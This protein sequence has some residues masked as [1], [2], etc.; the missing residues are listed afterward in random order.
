[1]MALP[2][3]TAS[4]PSVLFRGTLKVGHGSWNTKL[5]P[6]SK[7]DN[8]LPFLA[9][10][11]SQSEALFY[12]LWQS[13]W[14]VPLPTHNVLLEQLTISMVSSRMPPSLVFSLPLQTS[15]GSENKA[16]SFICSEASK[17]LHFAARREIVRK[18]GDNPLQA[19]S[20]R[21]HLPLGQLDGVSAQPQDTGDQE[22]P[23]TWPG[24]QKA[25]NAQEGL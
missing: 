13:N 14:F 22:I 12:L 24:L 7:N 4:G 23:L 20:G 3:D 21:A 25:A 6:E 5:C 16:T 18:S 10:H 1:M 17:S 2:L 9:K 11:R 15:L 8:K 19:S